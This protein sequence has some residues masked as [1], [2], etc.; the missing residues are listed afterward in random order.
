MPPKYVLNTFLVKLSCRYNLSIY[1]Y[2]IISAGKKE[3]YPYF[4]EIKQI[5]MNCVNVFF[6]MLKKRTIFGNLM[7]EF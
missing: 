2:N 1:D 4:L 7:L 5:F 6:N 3:K